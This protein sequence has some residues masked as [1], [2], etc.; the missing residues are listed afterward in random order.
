LA[1]P[2]EGSYVHLANAEWERIAD[3]DPDRAV[4]ADIYVVENVV[5][6]APLRTP[7]VVSEPAPS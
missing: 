4:P 1:V 5:S 6:S 2:D 3:P 7:T